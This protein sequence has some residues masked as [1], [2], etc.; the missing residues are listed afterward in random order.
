[1]ARFLAIEADSTVV[2]VLAGQM[3]GGQVRLERWFQFDAGSTL[4]PASADDIGRAL[5]DKLKE[6]KI[7]PAPLLAVVGRDRVVLKEFRIP[8]VAEHEEPPVVRF[9][10]LKALA[11]S[12]DDVVLDYVPMAPPGPEGRKVQV[13]SIRKDLVKAFRRVAEAAGLKLSAIT[14]RPFALVAGCQSAIRTGVV[15]APESDDTAWA[16]LARS[17]KWGEFLIVRQGVIV[18]SRSLAGPALSS[19]SALLGEIRRNLVVYGNQN[20][21]RPVRTL[22]LAEAETPGGLAE[23][24]QQALAIPVH[25]YEPGVGIAVPDGLSG[26]I[27]GLAGL[28]VLRTAD[29][30]APNFIAPRQPKPPADPAKR[31]FFLGGAIAAACF[32]AFVMYAVYQVRI[33]TQQV[34]LLAE[35]ASRQE[36]MVKALD[37]D[38][39]K[40][41]ALEEWSSTDVNWLDE[42]YDLTARMK[43][44]ENVRLKSV[45]ITPLDDRTVQR[46]PAGRADTN[47][48]QV[49]YAFT[50]TIVG[51]A[52]SERAV[53]ALMAELV[54]ESVYKVYAKTSKGIPPRL[55]AQG[56]EQEFTTRVEIPKR[57]PDQY[58]RTLPE[59]TAGSTRRGRGPRDDGESLGG[60]GP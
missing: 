53:N 51:L 14:P 54:A 33:R 1:M 24:L 55:T 30:E 34:D 56:Y 39:K 52:K 43:D 3:K 2:Q 42:L 58:T 46:K 31:I 60:F 25:C 5:R 13:V 20:P 8:R 36:E 10:E 32:L 15:P 50:M 38:W 22:Y 21:D 18:L 12:G 4:T 9:Q 27:A 23:R 48:K 35:D 17:E 11:E 6:E 47:T 19:D 28:F 7:A 57:R 16:L 26:T 49:A 59:R 29:E 44:T 45:T 41:K 37:P 40:I